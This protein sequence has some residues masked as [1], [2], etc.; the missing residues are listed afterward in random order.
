MDAG[1]ALAA[2]QRDRTGTGGDDQRPVRD[3][4]ARGVQLPVVRAYAGH[5]APQQQLD[6]ERAEVDV[7]GGAIGLAEQHGL[8]ERRSVVR[9]VGLLTDQ[10]DGSGEA[11]VPQGDSGLHSGHARTG[12]DDVPRLT[13]PVTINS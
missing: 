5:L 4:A 13:H 10:R 6:P 7:E 1:D 2:G 12:D 11:L 8:G 9:L 3:G